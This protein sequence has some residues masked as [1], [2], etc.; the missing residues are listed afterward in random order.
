VRRRGRGS[1]TGARVRYAFRRPRFP[2]VWANRGEVLS[3][4]SAATF[5]RQ[6]ER[7][8]LD[9][10]KAIDIVDATGE[11]WAF[12]TELMVVSPLTLKK[13]WTKIEVIRLFNGSDNA[14]R[15]GAAYPEAY[16]RRRSLDLI[17]AEVAALAA[18]AKPNKRTGALGGRSGRSPGAFGGG[19]SRVVAPDPAVVRRVQ[20][21]VMATVARH[22]GVPVAKLRVQT[23]LRV[24]PAALYRILLDI[25]GQLGV[26]PLDGNWSFNGDSIGAIVAY[27]ATGNIGNTTDREHG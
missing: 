3:A 7:L 26:H 15:T 1:I 24:D 19:D 22:I 12:H 10:V 25:E 27:C 17:I 18:H 8:D 5:Q 16:A 14:R 2:I 23:R 21:I 4:G 20:G 6:I 9:G 11:G 13:R